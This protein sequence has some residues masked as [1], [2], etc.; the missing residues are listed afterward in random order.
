[1]GEIHDVD[2]EIAAI[3]NLAQ[4]VGSFSGD[5]ERF[6]VMRALMRGELDDAEQWLQRLLAVAQQHNDRSLLFSYTGQLGV[7][8]GERGRALELSPLLSGTSSEMPQL[9]VVRMAMAVLYARTNRLSQARV[10][11]EYLAV[12]D[13]GVIPDD[14]NWL[15]TIALLA[16]VCVKIGDLDRAPI[17]HRLLAPYAGRSATLGYGDVYYN[18]VSHYLAILST[19]LGEMDRARRQFESA[20]RFNRRMGAGVA[21]AYTQVAYA[22]MLLQCEGPYERS[23]AMELLQV[24]RD[25]AQSMGLMGLLA[26]VENADEE[27]NASAAVEITRA[28]DRRETAIFRR[29]GDV[30]TLSWGKDRSG[31]A[32]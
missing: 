17:L 23:Q 13:F 29:E 21:L 30:W 19:A 18:C 27:A 5:L 24:A 16:E 11:F 15:G 8:L 7:L 3:E 10:E 6:G 4:S 1:M 32:I 26:E 28:I 22:R 9:P 14:W 31:S 25:T 12:D 20:L 2:I